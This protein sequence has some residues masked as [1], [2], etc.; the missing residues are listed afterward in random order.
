MGFVEIGVW[1]V[2]T[3]RSASVM[4]RTEAETFYQDIGSA[5]RPR[6]KGLEK[7]IAFWERPRS[8]EEEETTLASG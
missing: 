4:V 8:V 2:R 3:G 1:G 7:N 6:I 5:S